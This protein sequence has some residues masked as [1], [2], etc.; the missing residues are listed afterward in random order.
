MI[1]RYMFDHART[2]VHL[3]QKLSSLPTNN[4]DIKPPLL[5]VDPERFYRSGEKENRFFL[6]ESP[7]GDIRRKKLC[8]IG[9]VY[10]MFVRIA[11]TIEVQHCV[12]DWVLERQ[13]RRANPSV[14]AKEQTNEG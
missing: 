3:D 2:T 12:C 4:S 5:V 1:L 9:E 13:E 6:R 7:I 14:F 8:M 10:R 11:N